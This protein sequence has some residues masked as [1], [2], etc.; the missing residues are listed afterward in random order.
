VERSDIKVEV[1]NDRLILTMD[2]SQFRSIYFMATDGTR[3][4]QSESTAVDSEVPIRTREF[5]E[6]AWEAATE[7][8]RELG[9]AD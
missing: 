7:K 8:A 3:L 6:L 2:G 5:K 4:V 1:E 9:W